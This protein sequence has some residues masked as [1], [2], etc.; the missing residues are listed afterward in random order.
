[1]QRHIMKNREL[2]TMSHGQRRNEYI[3]YNDSGDI[4]DKLEVTPSTAA[5]LINSQGLQMQ[6]AMHYYRTVVCR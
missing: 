3:I 4:L 6:S 1:M 5:W 2:F